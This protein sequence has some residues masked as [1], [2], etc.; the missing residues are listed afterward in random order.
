MIF[1]SCLL[2]AFVST[3]SLT[4]AWLQARFL[5]AILTSIAQR[6]PVRPVLSLLA[7][8]LRVLL[9]TAPALF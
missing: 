5:A 3:L 8:A 9:T 4:L 2:L 6:G 1:F 7:R